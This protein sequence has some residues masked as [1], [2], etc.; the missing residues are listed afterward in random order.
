MNKIIN[1]DYNN[2]LP[3]VSSNT[4]GNDIGVS[5]VLKRCKSRAINLFNGS[6]DRNVL[7]NKN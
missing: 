3:Q 6:R 4:N 2:R 7:N 1:G 5:I